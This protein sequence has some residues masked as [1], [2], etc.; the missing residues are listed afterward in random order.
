V[1]PERSPRSLIHQLE[2]SG[3]PL[4]ILEAVR[5]LRGYL[6]R[7]EATALC[8]ARDASAS[9]TDIA[10]ALGT[11]RQ[12]VYNRLKQLAEEQRAHE[13]AATIVIPELELEPDAD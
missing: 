7:M 13:A 3:V 8:D 2:T 11:T 1:T 12:T 10:E 4:K 6:D 9:I 5:E